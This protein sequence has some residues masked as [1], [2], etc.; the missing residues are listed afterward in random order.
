VFV[1]TDGFG[2]TIKVDK[3]EKWHWFL[4]ADGTK[5]WIDKNCNI[6]NLKDYE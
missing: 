4:T 6:Y 5:L 3:P 1:L 2:D